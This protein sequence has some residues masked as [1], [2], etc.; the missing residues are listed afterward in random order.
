MQR[1]EFSSELR[2]SFTSYNPTAIDARLLAAVYGNELTYESFE[3]KRL[4]E[5]LFTLGNLKPVNFKEAWFV[6][7]QSLIFTC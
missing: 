7:L 1:K 6:G 4:K 5:N 3:K 2:I